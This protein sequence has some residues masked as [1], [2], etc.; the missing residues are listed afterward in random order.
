MVES[1][2]TVHCA[3]WRIL[4]GVD[5]VRHYWNFWSDRRPRHLRRFRARE[6][7][8]VPALCVFVGRFCGRDADLAN[9]VRAMS[10]KSA[11]A[12]RRSSR[13]LDV[14]VKETSLCI[15]DEAGR[16]CREMKV[17]KAPTLSGNDSAIRHLTILP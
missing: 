6:S 4:P 14:S 9:L 3:V 15:V 10:M 16:I 12:P 1:C 17:V 11:G 8:S 2:R 13:G 5:V 7:S